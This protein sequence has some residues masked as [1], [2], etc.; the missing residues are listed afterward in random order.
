[1]FGFNVN[2]LKPNLKMAV[3]RIGIVKNKKANA[4]LAQRRE[5][6]RLLAERKAEKA[7]IRVEG[8]IRDDFTMEGYEILE[9]MCEMLAERE[10]PQSSANPPYL[11]CVPSINPSTEATATAPDALQASVSRLTVDNYT[12]QPSHLYSTQQTSKHQSGDGFTESDQTAQ[13]PQ[14]TWDSTPAAPASASY[15]TQSIPDFDD[16]TA[17]FERYSQRQDRHDPKNFSFT[18]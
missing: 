13:A 9:L 17:R 3:H 7:R 2:K 1:M 4:A 12:N 15:A 18:F 6:A 10:A 8:I 5:V 16:L 14:K 11:P